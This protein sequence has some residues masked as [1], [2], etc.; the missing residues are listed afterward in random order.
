MEELLFYLSLFIFVILACIIVVAR[1]T[2][3]APTRAAEDEDEIITFETLLLPLE[4]AS[5]NNDQLEQA[6]RRLFRYYDELDMTTTQKRFFLYALSKHPNVR[7]E[8]VLEALDEMSNLN[9][10]IAKE[11]EASVKRGLDRRDLVKRMV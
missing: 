5:S 7:A 2:K 11:L 10:S 1:F 4:F 3:P 9:P 6:V 8:L